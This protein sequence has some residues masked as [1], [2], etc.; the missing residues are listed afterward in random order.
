MKNVK[1]KDLKHHLQLM[2]REQTQTSTGGLK[3]VWKAGATTWGLV[4]PKTHHSGHSTQDPSTAGQGSLGLLPPPR[5]NVIVPAD[6]NLDKVRRLIWYEFFK[7]R[8]LEFTSLPQHVGKFHSI[9]TVE[10][11]HDQH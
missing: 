1:L 11:P 7:S 5:Y 3:E 2:L 8:T 9:Q 6:C 10:V 4:I